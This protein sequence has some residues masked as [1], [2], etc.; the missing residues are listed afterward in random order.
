VKSSVGSENETHKTH[1]LQLMF[2]ALRAENP[3]QD[4]RDENCVRVS[5]LLNC[6]DLKRKRSTQT[7]LTCALRASSQLWREGLSGAYEIDCQT[8]K[9]FQSLQVFS[10]ILILLSLSSI[11]IEDLHRRMF[12]LFPSSL[13]QFFSIHQ[14]NQ[15][16]L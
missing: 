14:F 2:I 6:F 13:F 5:T 4:Q 11:A 8:R 16:A 9:P 7:A 12:F 15:L 1:M 10:Y 3:K